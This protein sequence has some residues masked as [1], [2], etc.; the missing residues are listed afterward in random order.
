MH[1]Y[2]QLEI[3]LEMAHP[4][5]R[6]LS[7]L[8]GPLSRL[9]ASLGNNHPMAGLMIFRLGDVMSLVAPNADLDYATRDSFTDTAISKFNGQPLEKPL[10]PWLDGGLEGDAL[11]LDDVAP[12]GDDTVRGEVQE[13]NLGGF[14]GLLGD[15]HLVCP[16]G[17]PRI[18][19]DCPGIFRHA[20]VIVVARLPAQGASV[21]LRMP[22]PGFGSTTGKNGGRGLATSAW[23]TTPS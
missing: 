11:V 3:V 5:E 14:K 9:L 21:C 12:D 15:R 7:P 22:R 6:G 20:T 4:V 13:S 2:A 23:C 16:S 10:E 19:L 18:N 8:G 17:R 1:A